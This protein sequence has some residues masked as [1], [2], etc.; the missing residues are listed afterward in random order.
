MNGL[1]ETV[2]IWASKNKKRK[3]ISKGRKNHDQIPIIK[4]PFLTVDC[5]K[6]IKN[7]SI[8]FIFPHAYCRHVTLAAQAAPLALLWL[9]HPLL[10]ALRNGKLCQLFVFYF[11]EKIFFFPVSS[12]WFFQ[13]KIPRF[14]GLPLRILTPWNQLFNRAL[15]APAVKP[16][17]HIANANILW[18]AITCRWLSPAAINSAFSASRTPS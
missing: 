16:V 1:W 8:I 10:P 4:R 5:G 7:D 11:A 2:N 13:L 17:I 18:R 9:M 3:Q 14:S 6:I 15:S 12:P